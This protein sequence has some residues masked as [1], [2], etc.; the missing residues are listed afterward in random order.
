ME[1]NPESFAK[2]TIDKRYKHIT[3]T[4]L[5]FFSFPHLKMSSPLQDSHLPQKL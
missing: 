4:I 3:I 1:K 5:P 2:Q